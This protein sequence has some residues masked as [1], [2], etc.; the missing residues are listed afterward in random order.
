MADKLTPEEEAKAKELEQISNADKTQLD[1]IGD[2]I[3]DLVDMA[4]SQT[5]DDKDKPDPDKKEGLDME[6]NAEEM[7]KSIKETDDPKKFIKELVGH[8]EVGL[9]DIF[10]ETGE[11]YF[12]DDLIK[13]LQDSEEETKQILNGL[14]IANKTQSE[15]FS[16][17][18][19][20]MMN[21]NLGMVKSLEGLQTEMVEMK[22]SMTPT[23]PDANVPEIDDK[24]P[25]LGDEA[26]KDAISA[27]ADLSAQ[28]PKF[29]V[30]QMLSALHK[31]FG[32]RDT[33]KYY[34]YKKQL[35]KFGN[36]DT[37]Y[38]NLE[39]TAHQDSLTVNNYL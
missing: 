9:E 11:R 21:L 22:K 36:A 18:I 3:A 12:D 5:E 35:Q 32:D 15:R 8:C 33:G 24:L 30:D 39:R 1:K 37:F 28:G 4:K 19:G 10:D 14:V 13:S 17:A 34:K 23:I 27:D 29:Q 31:S 25:P 2:G 16:K 20:V 7:A 38:A 6:L 26:A